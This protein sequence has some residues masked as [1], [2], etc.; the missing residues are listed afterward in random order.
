MARKR[1]LVVLASGRGTNLQAIL[2]AVRAGALPAEVALVASDKP[3]PALE[4]AERARVPALYL[5]P[6]KGVSRED[7][8]ALLADFVAAARPDLV[9]LAGWMRILTPVFL[10]R[11]P[12]R[13]INLHPAL[14]GAFPGLDA[15]RRNYQAY[16]R[17]QATT[18]GVMVHYAV[19]EVDAGPVILAEPVPIYPGDSLAAFEARVHATEHRLIVEAIRRVLGR[20]AG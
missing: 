9:V 2:D 8:D 10:D 20:D 1:R 18:G 4:R 11:F 5:P 19:P 16:R 14:P 12:N 13:V 15:I 17:G 3:S 7:Y 6:R